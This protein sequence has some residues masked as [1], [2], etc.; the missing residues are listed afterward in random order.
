MDL[1]NSSK[2]PTNKTDFSSTFTRQ[3]L[4]SLY[5]AIFALGVCLNGL[6]AWIFLRVPAD[7]ALVVYLKNMVV[8]DILMLF[9]FPVRVAAKMN[10]DSRYLNMIECRFNAVLFYISMYVGLLFIAYISLER[11]VKISQNVPSTKATSSLRSQCRGVSVLHLMQSTTFSQV[12]AVLTWSLLFLCCSPNSIL[13]NWPANSHNFTKCIQLKTPLGKQWHQATSLFTW[14]LFW[15]TLII[16]A[17]SY[18]FIARQ[19]YKTYHCMRRD[20]REVYRNSNRN[21]FSILGVFCICFVP[22]HVCRIPY[23]MSQVSPT[24]F[25]QD[26]KFWLHQIKEGTLFLSAMNVCLDPLV[27]FLMCGT[28]R[29]SLIRKLSGRKK[30][31]PLSTD[32]S[33]SKM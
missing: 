22:F 32:L 1:L 17:F 13:T 23:T 21:I 25:S 20:S 11:Y 4:P 14:S 16:V 15:L 19:V 6:A 9:S 29:K 3:V 12:L 31:K 2:L 5:I 26:S 8:A 7:S 18:T 10:L 27:Y 33:L 30:R 28:F 24:H